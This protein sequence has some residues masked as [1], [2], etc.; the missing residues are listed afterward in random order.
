MYKITMI[1][2]LALGI[3]MM[4]FVA[5]HHMLH[6]IYFALLEILVLIAHIFNEMKR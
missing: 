3:T 5:T 4:Y 2:M 6:A 1:V